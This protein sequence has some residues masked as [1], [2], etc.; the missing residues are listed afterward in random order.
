MMTVRSEPGT[1]EPTDN[2]DSVTCAPDGSGPSVLPSTVLET[3]AHAAIVSW[4]YDAPLTFNWSPTGASAGLPST[5]YPSRTACEASITS[6]RAAD[7][8][9]ARYPSTWMEYCPP[10]KV[11]SP[12]SVVWVRQ[13]SLAGLF[14]FWLVTNNSALA[15]RTSGSAMG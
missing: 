2:T 9:T 5:P 10:D 7:W 11:R 3:V 14:P 12:L 15:T 4:Q 13:M 6:A 1:V 8:S